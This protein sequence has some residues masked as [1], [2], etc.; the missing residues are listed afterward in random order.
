M[1][2][3]L[4]EIVVNNNIVNSYIDLFQEEDEIRGFDDDED[5]LFSNEI[6]PL[7]SQEREVDS[8]DDEISPAQ[9][10]SSA[11]PSPSA[12]SSSS[13]APS[14]IQSPSSSTSSNDSPSILK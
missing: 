10:S 7:V 11:S 8:Y 4:N 6:L 14:S 12:S 3:S 2:K 13:A 5:E 9:S 1:H